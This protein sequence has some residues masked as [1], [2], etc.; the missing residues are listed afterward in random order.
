LIKFASQ[1][2]SAAPTFTTYEFQRELQTRLKGR[3]LHI[4]RETMNMESLKILIKYGLKMED[5]LLDPLR[6]SIAA[7]KVQFDKKRDQE[8]DEIS[9]DIEIISNLA[10]KRLRD[11]YRYFPFY[12]CNLV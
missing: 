6:N 8:K 10:W 9:K 11:S 7:A 1:L 3:K 2:R 5:E 12:H 4:N